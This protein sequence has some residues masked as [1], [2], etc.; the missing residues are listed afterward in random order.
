MNWSDTGIVL[1][2]RLYGET[3]TIVHLITKSHGR[4]AGLV[5]GGAGKKKKSIIQPGNEVSVSWRARLSEH[6]GNFSVELLRPRAALVLDNPLRLAAL[7][8]ATEILDC[9]LPERQPYPSVYSSLC[10]M[11]DIV[12]KGEE[13]WI[14]SYINWEVLLLRE[15]GFGLDLSQADSLSENWVVSEK[16]GEVVKPSRES[17]Q[18]SVPNI[19]LGAPI[20]TDSILR[21][22]AFTDALR[23]TGA[24]LLRAVGNQRVLK[25]RVRFVERI[26]RKKNLSDISRIHE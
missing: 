8:A 4:H 20:P 24:F 10:E 1:S 13:N 17:R 11:L 15:L 23:L 14:M 25:N 7:I 22:N 16:S 21:T 12:E 9:A 26:S 6:L 18:L 3:S 2:A 5:R 19:L